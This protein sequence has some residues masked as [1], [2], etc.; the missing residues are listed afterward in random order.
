MLIA[1]GVTTVSEQSCDINDVARAASDLV[2]LSCTIG[3]TNF[4]DGIIQIQFITTVSNFVNEI[5]KDVND[6]VISAWV[7]VQEIKA[8]YADL[9]SKALFYAQNGIGV[10]AGVMQIEIGIAITGTSY[11]LGA[12]AGAFF[13][14]H[15]INNIYEGGM[16]IYNGPTVSVAEGPT[17]RAYRDILGDDYNGDM[18]YGAIDLFLS[19]S[20]MMRP[21]RKPDSVQL[22]RR[23][24]INYES[25]YQQSGRLAL[26]FEALVNS[27][28]ISSMV[29]G[30]SPEIKSK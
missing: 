24:P 21:V 13:V 28:T 9:T 20:G 27:I 23:D 5:V 4:Y 17:R 8:E 14:A 12:P 7:G 25:A 30:E 19:A 16:N 6:G 2:S 11:G 18:A 29:S 22:F 3:A 10:A 15:G 26:L 1:L